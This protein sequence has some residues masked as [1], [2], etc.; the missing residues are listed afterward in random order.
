[1]YTAIVVMVDVRVS[2]FYP[3]IPTRLR[4]N[5][6]RNKNAT[7]C[8]AGK[9]QKTKIPYESE[10]R[11]KDYCFLLS[12]YKTALVWE[13][14]VR[15]SKILSFLFLH[16]RDNISLLDPRLQSVFVFVCRATGRSK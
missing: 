11:G 1:M 10:L 4:E 8:G 5:Q 14:E 3:F 6:K 13:Q 15:G 9:A 2:S 16:L 12:S 7:S